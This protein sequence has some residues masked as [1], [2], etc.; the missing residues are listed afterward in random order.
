MYDF[1]GREGFVAKCF[2]LKT[3]LIAYMSA[4]KNEYFMPSQE[5]FRKNELSKLW[6]ERMDIINQL[7]DIV[8]LTLA[9]NIKLLV[10]VDILIR[11]IS[12]IN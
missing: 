4:I 3:D 6:K 8:F 5:Y 2:M 11:M 9:T 12:D 1:Y 10:L 7:D